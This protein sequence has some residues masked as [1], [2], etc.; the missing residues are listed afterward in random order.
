MSLAPEVINYCIL[1]F[2]LMYFICFPKKFF[3]VSSLI[4]TMLIFYE[5]PSL[6][7]DKSIC[8]K[9]A[10][11]VEIT[12]SLPRNILTSISLVEAGRKH[13]DGLVQSWPWSLNHAGKSLFFDE[14]AEALEYL[15]KNITPEF[16]NI[17]VGCM[18]INV[19][20]HRENFD[21]LDA[22]LDP[23]KNIEYAASFLTTLKSGKGSWEKAIKH[24]H[25]ATPKL[26]VK[27]YAKVQTAWDKKTNDNSSVHRAVLS[28]DS[29][30]KYPRS[31][32]S[33]LDFAGFDPYS[34]KNISGTKKQSLELGRSDIYDDNDI[35]L[36]AVIIKNNK[37]D[38][39][40]DLKR[41]IKY[42]SA[43]LG[44]KID[45]ILLFREEFSKN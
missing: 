25:S 7:N 45:M 39:K 29:H 16:K 33:Q 24:Y 41:Y 34:N 11:D 42:N 30:I 15:E 37:A 43:Y 17:D 13:E 38:N 32:N 26:N 19:R 31:A 2:D 44:K 28:R 22:M 8:D 35:F 10:R 40:E 20:W 21:S 12:N 6:A 18:Q 27:Y 1:R 23:R 14:K 9:I 5:E 4:F 3:L 36:N